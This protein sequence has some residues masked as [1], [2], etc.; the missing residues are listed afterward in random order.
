[1]KVSGPSGASSASGPRG[2]KPAAAAGGFAPIVSGGGA[3]DVARTS[4]AAGVGAVAS[5]EALMA[6]QDIGGPLERRRRAT[7]RGGRLLDALEDL[8]IG[9]LD[10][11]LPKG[12]V[13][14][15]AREAREQ[16][17]MTDDPGLDAILGEIE[18]RAEVELAKLEVNGLAA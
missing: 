8:K 7:A 3:S 16:R 1:M 10:G 12:A 4:A 15:L 17:A 14:R 2:A 13:E 18:M 11:A 6:L 9:L 5:L